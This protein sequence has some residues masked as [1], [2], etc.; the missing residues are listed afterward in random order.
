M[1]FGS[2]ETSLA[3][4]VGQRINEAVQ[5]P[6]CVIQE[7]GSVTLER[8]DGVKAGAPTEN[9]NVNGADMRRSQSTLDREAEAGPAIDYMVTLG[10][11]YALAAWHR[12]RTRAARPRSP[13]STSTPSDR[14]KIKGGTYSS[15]STSS[16]TC[17]A[18]AVDSLWLYMNNGNTIGGGSQC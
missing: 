13:P 18:T 6:V 4:A 16:P 14:R 12:W 2:D 15:P 1:Y 17:R 9:I 8:C 5:A 7:Q 11:P 10:A 3:E